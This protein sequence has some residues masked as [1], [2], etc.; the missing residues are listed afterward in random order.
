MEDANSENIVNIT[1][2]F[3]DDRKAKEVFAR[4]DYYLKSGIHIQREHP[5]PEEM[6]RFIEKNYDSLKL[7][8]MDFFQ[9]VLSKGGDEL[10]NRYYFL[11]FEDENSRGKIPSDHR[12]RKYL[13][14][15]HIIIGML[16]LK[17]Y[18]LD[19]NIE[20]DT[21]TDFIQLLF[22]EYEEEKIGLFKL[23]ASSKTDKSTDYVDK[24]V[25]KEIHDAFDEFEKIGWI[26][27]LDDNKDKFKYMAS[28]ERLR[29]KYQ[30][31]IINID[32]I[33]NKLNAN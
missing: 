19:A 12:Y 13:E 27:W 4:I 6:F 3:L 28:F 8:Y 10:I 1:Y 30:S 17:I 14:T 29:K 24:D 15:A 9:L 21:V 22:T 5:K 23:I 20:L 2:P 31:Q 33:I 26:M 25:L 18:R 11:D 16:F 32:E 7:Y